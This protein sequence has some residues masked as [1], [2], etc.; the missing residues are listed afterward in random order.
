MERNTKQRDA[1]RE[2]LEE[3][4]H[5]LAPNDILLLAQEKINAVGIA[6]VY[7]Q[8][9]SLQE[10]GDIKAVEI[11]GQSPR[12]EKAHLHHH[13]HFLCTNCNKLFEV[14]SCPGNVD[15]LAPEGFKVSRHE[16]TLYGEC[17]SCLAA[18]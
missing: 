14:H 9:K 17:E 13:H 5:P 3:A 18:K 8:L 1:I 6:T 15:E 12:Y 10:T 2:V 4:E 16:I 11:A 7:R